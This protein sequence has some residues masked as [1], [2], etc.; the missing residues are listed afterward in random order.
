MGTRSI[1]RSLIL[2]ASFLAVFLA[3]SPAY[4][5]AGTPLVW[6]GMLHLVVGNIF[7]GFLEGRIIAAFLGV[8]KASA[9]SIMIAANFTSMLIGYFSFEGFELTLAPKFLG[10]QPLYNARP[11]LIMLVAASF[12]LTV[13]IE[14]PFCLAAVRKLDSRLKKSIFASVLVQTVSYA[15]LVPFYFLASGT[16]LFTRM[17]IDRSVVAKSKDPV[18]IF[19]ISPKDGDVYR[20]G[21]NGSGLEKVCVFGGKDK[22]ARLFLRKAEDSAMWDLWIRPDRSKSSDTML[23]SGLTS[24]AAEPNPFRE[25]NEYTWFNFGAAADMRAEDKR[26]WNVRTGFWAF[27]GLSARNEET[28]KGFTVALETPFLE[29]YARNATVL[30]SDKVVYQLGDQIVLLDMNTRKI[31]LV[32]IGRGPV[33][34]LDKDIRE[35]PRPTAHPPGNHKAATASPSNPH[36]ET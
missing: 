26:S 5:D 7:I 27:E 28:R 4:A 16:S 3:S 35:Q 36:P 17:D 21:L 22:V 24:G 33:V 18:M 31:G 15:L 34:V 12:V 30:P 9:V 25:D 1:K 20:I 6:A 11:L 23:V 19:F 13:L 8:R 29:W 2:P 32:T 10:E 14:W